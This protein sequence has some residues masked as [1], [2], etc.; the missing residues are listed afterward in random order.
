MLCLTTCQI[1]AGLYCHSIVALSV[2]NPVVDTAAQ[3]FI[4]LLLAVS[5]IEPPTEHIHTC[6]I[7]YLLPKMA[8]FTFAEVQF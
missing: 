5:K 2:M 3:E 1:W 4:L 6:P 7:S 8:V